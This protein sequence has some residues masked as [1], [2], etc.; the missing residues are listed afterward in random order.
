V[1]KRQGA[2]SVGPGGTGGIRSRE[3]EDNKTGHPN[4]RRKK[5]STATTLGGRRDFDYV[6]GKVPDRSPEL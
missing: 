3:S 2:K 5:K 6:Q 4:A 1:G